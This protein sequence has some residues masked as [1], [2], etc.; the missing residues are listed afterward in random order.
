MF[1]H[2]VK[3]G[4]TLFSIASLYGL[5]P[6]YLQN[7]NTLPNPENLVVGQ[8][9][10]VLYPEILHTIMPGETLSSI[11]D[12]YSV[13]II[14]LIRNNPQLE[15]LNNITPGNQLVIKFQGQNAKNRDVIIN[16]YTYADLTQQYLQQVMPYLTYITS[17]TYGINTDGSLIPVDDSRIISLA[18]AYG[19]SPLMHLSTLTSQGV[20]SNAL[21]GTILNDTNLQQKIIENVLKEIEEKGYS[22]LDIDFEFLP[23]E[24]SKDYAAFV[25]NITRTLNEKGY[26]VI[27]A[28]APKTSSDQKGLLYEGHNYA[29]L[30]NAAN[31]AFVMTYEWG[32][33]YGPPMAVAPIQSVERVLEYAITEIP[34]EKILMGLPSYGYNWTLPYK[35]GES[36]AQSVSGITAVELASQY[37][38]EIYFDDISQTPYFYYTDENGTV[39]EIWFEDAR[40]ILAKLNLIEE[41]SL[42][43]GGYWN[44][45]RP[46]PQNWMVLN[47]I[48][49]IL[50]K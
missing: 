14:S 42:A 22:G 30:G 4:E 16:A 47:N 46:F 35:K 29:L 43:G 45:E 9:I 38:A 7:I 50:Q 15:N 27:V 26:I 3:Q 33:T 20:F 40:S 18:N 34:P 17:F 1:I 11:A 13:S 2:T 31:Y 44:L 23:A 10:L 39:H 48:Y 41:Y 19:V 49:N 25:Q 28:L 36:K 12:Y 6:S 32:Y 37:G 21:A 5:T 8:S 24:N